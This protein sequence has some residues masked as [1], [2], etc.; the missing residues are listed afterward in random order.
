MPAPELNA[1]ITQKT[2]VAPGLSIFHIR[3]DGWELPEF[4]PGQFIAVGLPGSAPRYQFSDAEIEPAD[5]D[6]FIRRAYSI[7]SGSVDKDYIEIYVSLVKSGA[8]TP[9]LFNLQTGDRVFLNQKISGMFTLDEVP[10]D[11]NIILV[12]TGTGV[13]P[14]MSMLRSSSIAND[15]RKYAVVH[16]AYNSWDLGYRSELMM[17]ERLTKN[18]T[19]IPTITDIKNE[20]LPWG[21][22]VGFVQR[23][24]EQKLV[25]E[26]WGE[27]VTPENT[28]IFLCGH[29]K[30]IEDMLELVG[31]EGF[32]E[33]KKKDPGTVHVEKF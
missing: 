3:P 1:V 22:Q 33:H 12:A 19:Y 7:A 17:I 24:W 10:E 13:A 28:H 30:M 8:L 32:K 2:E 20:P 29:P 16:G 4:K 6:K 27:K 11:H 23:I 15:K 5:P 21:G 26:K 31:K 9:R 18:F 14:Y 25:D